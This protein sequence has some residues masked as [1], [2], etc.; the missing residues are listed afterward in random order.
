[1]SEIPP[2]TP[3]Q[4]DNQPSSQT[5]TRLL[6]Q[7]EVVGYRREMGR[8]TMFSK[9]GYGWSAEPIAHDDR[10][11]QASFGAPSTR[12]FHGDIVEMPYR[13]DAQEHRELV[14]VVCTQGQDALFDPKTGEADRLSVLWP[15]PNQPFA[16][17]RRG[18]VWANEELSRATR[19]VRYALASESS[20]SL[21]MV[22]EGSASILLGVLAVGLLQMAY[23]GEIG[24]IS[25]LLGGFAASLLR[26]GRWRKATP[27]LLSRRWA[28]TVTWRIALLCGALAAAVGLALGEP[29]PRVGGMALAA[30][31][32]SG[33]VWIL[34]ADI[35]A[36]RTGGYAREESKTK[37]PG[38][39]WD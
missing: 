15:P 29:V 37:R 25:A 13:Y 14:V 2:F 26:V 20:P 3:P 11:P 16:Q 35:V 4:T 33:L 36:W 6:R 12:L 22:A 30:V 5:W 39:R 24:P 10:L 1:M 34:A 8:A 32:F 7:G 19:S 38:A 31:L 28:V 9:D 23:F 17:V 21:R 18:S 27:L